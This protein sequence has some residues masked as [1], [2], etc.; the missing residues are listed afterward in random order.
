[1]D[2]RLLR[3]YN[4]ELRY[5][6]ELGSEFAREFPKIAARLG[7][8]G[9]E[10]ADPYVER[11]L[12][13]SAF[14]A[15]RVQLKQDAEFP[16]FSQRLLEL[17]YPNFLA[18]TPAMMVAQLHPVP[19]PNLLQAPLIPRDSPVLGPASSKSATRC[20]FR[21]AQDVRLTPLSVAKADYFLNVSDLGL[22][23]YALPRRPRAGLRLRLQLPAGMQMQALALDELVI[24][25]GG[26][27]EVAMRLH[28]LLLSGTIAVLAGPPGKPDARRLLPGHAVQ[29]VGYEDD[30]ALL[31]NALRG[32]AGVRLLQEYF[33]FPERFLFFGI[34][35][36]RAAL[37]A[38]PGN[39]LEIVLLLA[40]PGQG[41]D[42][43]VDAQNFLLNCTPAVNLF[44]KR[45][46][47]IQLDEGHHEFQVVPDRSAPL[48]Y[49]VYEVLSL[50]GYDDQ[51]TER[52]FLP[53][54][55]PSHATLPGQ[56]AYYTTWREPRLVSDRA[57]REG[58]RSGYIG[59]EVFV[60]LVDTSETPYPT[61]LRQLSV[62]TRCTNRDLPVFL[63]TGGL[64]EF[65]LDA[66]I[67]LKTVRAVAGPSRPHT[68]LRE[69]GIAWRFINLLSQNYLSIVE[70]G[71][72]EAVAALRD[73]LSRFP[74]GEEAAVRRQIEALQG[75]RVKP[76]VRRH[77]APGPIAFARGIE[78]ELT[79]DE[80]GYQ[81][82][83]AHLFG[84]AMHH[85]LSRHV[86]MNS[87]VET[88]L[89]SLTRGEIMRWK[90]SHGR[91]AVL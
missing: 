82:G 35:G 66:G 49:E 77:P 57:R 43:V 61:T 18:P 11:L 85:Y 28:E 83:S 5:L 65:T 67:P 60:S 26:Q 75:V 24:Y 6:R 19:D 29:A 91:R 36:L 63:G 40:E 74:Q 41:L 64:S 16:R 37:Q 10:V 34:A 78:I 56:P 1:M 48:D 21:T 25:L 32:F 45:A 76:V 14:L 86:S 70:S 50:H 13:G 8:D 12:E 22:S 17:V 87:F 51:G 54:Y 27:T 80:L 31:P 90:P 81:G 88:T 4:Q 62:Q 52:R 69:G 68:A 30:Q 7:M 38:C 55:A 89:K 84:A 2:P 59:S 44:P 79:V 39:E 53:L 15:A 33:A 23:A 46:D 73:L 3:Y 9:L 47:R 42:G 20:E 71:E 72:G 58:P